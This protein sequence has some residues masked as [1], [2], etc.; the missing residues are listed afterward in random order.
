MSRNYDRKHY[1]KENSFDTSKPA[2][3][4]HQPGLL[5][6][7]QL[8]RKIDQNLA[9]VEKDPSNLLEEGEPYYKQG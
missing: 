7:G 1:D 6:N 5:S 9:L 3:V 8:R 4:H 2:G